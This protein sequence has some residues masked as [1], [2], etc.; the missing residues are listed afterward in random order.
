MLLVQSRHTKQMTRE[1]EPDI[2]AKAKAGHRQS[3]DRVILANYWAVVS[4][5]G[6]KTH[7][8]V[9]LEDLVSE[10]VLGLHRAIALYD[11][12]RGH[13]FLTYALWWVRVYIDDHIFSMA[14][15]VTMPRGCKFEATTAAKNFKDIQYVSG[16]ECNDIITEQDDMI[17]IVERKKIL[18]SLVGRLISREKD[19][20]TQHYGLDNDLPKTLKDIATDLGSSASW[21][22][23]IKTKGINNLRVHAAKYEFEL[24][25]DK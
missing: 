16:S 20:I 25:R 15:P 4:M 8:G 12:A 17:G 14:A 2:I 3:V 5:A 11:I 10:G 22:F 21:P 1:E 13:R 6:K 19:V 23:I 24:M 7:R 18:K 9:D